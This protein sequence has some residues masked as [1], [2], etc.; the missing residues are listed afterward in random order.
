MNAEVQEVDPES[1]RKALQK[2]KERMMSRIPSRKPPA[3]ETDDVEND[4]RVVKTATPK[5]KSEK[6]EE[7]DSSSEYTIDSEIL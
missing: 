2:R 4:E 3:L 6:V 1:L 7:I 5:R